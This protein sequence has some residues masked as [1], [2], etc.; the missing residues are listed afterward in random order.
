MGDATLNVLGQFVRN[1]T[2]FKK[3]INGPFHVKGKAIPVTCR[4][5]P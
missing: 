3:V 5:G 2:Y 1:K 4:G